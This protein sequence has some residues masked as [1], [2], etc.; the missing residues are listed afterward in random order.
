MHKSHLK[1]KEDD[2]W[3][4]TFYLF[5]GITRNIIWGISPDPKKFMI[6]E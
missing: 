1:A 3:M 2:E 4:D 6:N 5:L